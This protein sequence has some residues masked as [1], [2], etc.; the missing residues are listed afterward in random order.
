[1]PRVVC[2]WEVGVIPKQGRAFD[3]E[4]I[5]ASFASDGLGTVKKHEAATK[6]MTFMLSFSRIIMS[7]LAVPCAERDA[8]CPRR[9]MAIGMQTPEDS[10]VFCERGYCSPLPL[11]DVVS[12]GYMHGVHIAL[13]H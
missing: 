9:L 4:L 13:F 1:M 3:S 6:N 11:H 2:G 12:T 8:L 10:I 5:H 7:Q